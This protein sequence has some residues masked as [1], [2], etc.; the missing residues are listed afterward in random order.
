MANPLRSHRE[1]PSQVDASRWL[2]NGGGGGRHHAAEEWVHFACTSEDVN[3]LAYALMLSRARE[4]VLLPK[5]DE[6]IA[7]LRSLAEQHAGRPLLSL[8]HGQTA[9][10]TTFGKEMANVAHRMQHHRDILAAV[11]VVGKFNGATGNFNA[12]KVAYPDMDWQMVSKDFIT[13]SLGIQYQPF[14]TQIECH[15]YIAEIC[16][17]VGRFNTTLLDLDR[18]MWQY[19]SRGILKLKTVQGEV[20]S[21][22]MPH[23]VNP[24]DFENSEGNVGICHALSGTKGNDSKTRVFAICL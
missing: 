5:M 6:L 18:D 24:I 16:H 9:T 3:N 19:T 22:T 23:K 2:L 15:D 10:P 12:H 21:S 7:G 1:V 17:A 20:G 11:D 13:T 8:T 4:N 14:S